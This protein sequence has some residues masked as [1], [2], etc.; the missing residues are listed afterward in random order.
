M[1]GDVEDGEGGEEIAIF[2][3]YRCRGMSDWG[4]RDAVRPRENRRADP[5]LKNKHG[6]YY[7]ST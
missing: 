7:L 3:R 1:G 5:A 2:V 4:G 6:T